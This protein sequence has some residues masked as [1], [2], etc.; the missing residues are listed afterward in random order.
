M[1]NRYVIR[2]HFKG[3][4]NDNYP[5]ENHIVKLCYYGSLSSCKLKAINFILSSFKSVK[6]ITKIESVKN[7][8]F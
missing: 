5:L 3:V 8:V 2:I 4:I 1:K 6:E 7:G